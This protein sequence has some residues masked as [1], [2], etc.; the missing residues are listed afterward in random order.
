MLRS[1]LLAFAIIVAPTATLAVTSPCKG[2]AEAECGGKGECRWVAAIVKGEKSAKT[3]K[4]YAVSRRAY[5]RRKPGSVPLTA[6]QA[7]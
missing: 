1:V 5:C 2:L 3:G 4:T 7:Q 6:A